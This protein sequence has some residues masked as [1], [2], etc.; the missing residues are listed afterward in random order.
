MEWVLEQ[1]EV[2]KSIL[3]IINASKSRLFWISMMSEFSSPEVAAALEAAV[4]RGVR[5]HL[6]HSENPYVD[7]RQA[8]ERPSKDGA[9]LTVI[10]MHG[11]LLPPIIA[12]WLGR[13]KVSNLC[14]NVT[15]CRF[16]C[17]ESECLF[18]GVDYNL[19]MES[20]Y[21]VQHCLKL[22][23]DAAKGL[24]ESSQS[25]IDHITLHGGST[26]T[27]A[28]RYPMVGTSGTESSVL[29]V[30]LRCI[31]VAET[32]IYIEN[33]YIEDRRILQSLATAQRKRPSLRITLVG[34]LDFL[35]NPYH[36]G[37]S[38]CLGGILG[39]RLKRETLGGLEY[40]RALGCT[41]DFRTYPH[42]YTHNKIFIFDAHTIVVGTF[43]LHRRSM[44]AGNDAEIGVVVESSNLA[45]S[46][47]DRA[48]LHTTPIPEE[49][50]VPRLHAETRLGHVALKNFHVSA[51]AN[52][53]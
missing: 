33:Q 51:V 8:E 16:L 13:G 19:V 31:A 47:R 12:G 36:P 28:Y 41:F 9:T 40:L 53:V 29:Q 25:F 11:K 30:L 7:N 45:R 39:L 4:D 20:D 10:S 6:F 5:V 2:N 46:Y 26:N 42:K 1:S 37:A 48:L 24:T 32:E 17:N 38:N 52:K 22:N 43:N 15:H 49:L 35:R 14:F 50:V 34:N 3:G 44:T 23:L 21:Y 18:G 27:L